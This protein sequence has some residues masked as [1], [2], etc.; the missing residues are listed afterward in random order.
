MGAAS[1]KP[2]LFNGERPGCDWQSNPWVW[3]VSFS[4]ADRG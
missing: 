2:I 3:V 4:V 1:E